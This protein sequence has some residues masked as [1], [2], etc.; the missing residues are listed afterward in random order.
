MPIRRT[1]T[2]PRKKIVKRRRKPRPRPVEEDLSLVDQNR[3]PQ[4]GKFTTG[5]KA[6]F[7]NI[8]WR[9]VN[10]LIGIG[11]TMEEIGHVIGIS[12][13]TLRVRCLA[14]HDE[15]FLEYY[16]KHN[17]GFKIR[18]RRLQIHSA[19]GEKGVR[20]MVRKDQDG[21]V[22]TWEEEY[23]LRLPSVPVQIWLGKNYLGQSDKMETRQ[24]EDLVPEEEVVWRVTRRRDIKPG[25]SSDMEDA[26]L[27]EE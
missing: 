7:K 27:E 22:T 17:S 8:N 2:G 20:K 11:A 9:T 16:K 10:G 23:Y 5:N 21:N 24:I 4:S 14:E 25:P 6:A 19:E 3:D 26:I 12:A 1:K 18:L 15:P 13:E